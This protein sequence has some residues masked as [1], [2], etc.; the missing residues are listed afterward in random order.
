MPEIDPLYEG[1]HVLADLHGASGLSDVDR[2]AAALR[3]AAEAAGA[4]VLDVAL[5]HFGGGGGVTG[6]ALLAESH[7]SI[8]TWPERDYAAIDLFLCGRTN[9][10]EA[11]L[12]VL[13]AFFGP[14]RTDV[15]R[16]ARGFGS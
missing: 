5:H 3:S 10:P 1:W 13:E 6:V 7:I 12:A 8:H 14:A 15:K 4:T 9:D 2:I 16:I 11:A